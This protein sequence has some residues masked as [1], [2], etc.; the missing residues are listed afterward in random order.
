MET[1]V[2]SNGAGEL[3]ELVNEQV[4]IQRTPAASPSVQAAARLAD[5]TPR[6]NLGRFAAGS[7]RAA[8]RLEKYSRDQRL[9]WALP[10]PE[11]SGA[12]ASP[13]LGRGFRRMARRCR[14][15]GVA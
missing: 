5:F 15:A 11:A 8:R 1:G 4:K 6:N 13:A 2:M 7:A 12:E 3:G 14:A 9:I 10:E